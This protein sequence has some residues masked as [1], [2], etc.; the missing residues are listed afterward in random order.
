MVQSSSATAAGLFMESIFQHHS[1]PASVTGRHY[2]WHSIIGVSHHNTRSVTRSAFS[3]VSRRSMKRNP[4]LPVIT[5]AIRSS[6]F[7]KA[8]TRTGRVSGRWRR[9]NTL[10]P[11]SSRIS[12]GDREFYSSACASTPPPRLP[13]ALGRYFVYF[14]HAIYPGRFQ[15]AGRAKKRAFSVI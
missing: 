6:A 8:H 3:R 4:N 9:A 10:P 1:S 13:R 2:S 7:F 15:Y 5:D 11:R 12:A 14:L